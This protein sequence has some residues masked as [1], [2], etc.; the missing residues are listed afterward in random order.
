[1]VCTKGKKCIGSIEK[2]FI[3]EDES[4][5]FGQLIT[6]YR[7]KLGDDVFRW[8]GEDSDARRVVTPAL[9]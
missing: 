6:D 3:Y 7:A 1:V 2:E 9:A 4:T 5:D 8:S